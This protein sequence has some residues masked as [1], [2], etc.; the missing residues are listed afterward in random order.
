MKIIFLIT[1]DIK[2]PSGLGRFFPLAK[3]LSKLG[4][5]IKIFSLHSNYYTLKNKKEIYDQVEVFY[6]GQMQVRKIGNEKLYFKPIQLSF[7]MILA[8]IK[9]TYHVFVEDYDVIF[10][11]KPHPMNGIAGL[12]GKVFKRKKLIIDCDDLEFQSNNFKKKWQQDIVY[13]FEMNL[14][15]YADL[16]TTNTFFLKSRLVEVEIPEKKIYLL[17]NGIDKDRFSEN[18]A[19]NIGNLK[20]ELGLHDKKIVGFIGSISSVSHPIEILINAFLQL[21]NQIDNIHLLIVGGG[22]DF[23]KIQNKIIELG[24]NDA[25]SMV[26]RI[27]PEEIINYYKIC[28]ITVDPVYDDH[29]A[30]ARLPLKMFESWCVGVPFVTSDVGDRNIYLGNPPAGIIAK[31]DS[32]NE[33][34]KAIYLGL[35]NNELRKT[36]IGNGLTKSQKYYWNTLSSSFSD[37]LIS[38]M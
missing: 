5:Q 18:S 23:K 13:Y 12:F 22:E 9:F 20:T 1:Q 31:K 32:A 19:N 14:P 36:I 21:K 28:D 29:V 17:P 8:T 33:L 7:L 6:L 10:V 24:I 11:G 4:H 37:F 35:T 25:V 38:R 26:G 2:S 34:A 3:E 27:N 30:R 15:K 16:I